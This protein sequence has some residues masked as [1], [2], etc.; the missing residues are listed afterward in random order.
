MILSLTGQAQDIDLSKLELMDGISISVYARVNNPRQ[1]T[2][3]DDGTVYVGTRSGAGGRVF[4]L[5]NKDNNA[6]AEEV[7][8]IDK[9]LT[10]PHGVTYKDG[11][12]YVGARS[13]I[14]RY[15]DIEANLNNSKREIITD[16]LPTLSRHSQKHIAFGPDGLL[17]IPVGAPCNICIPEEEIFASLLTLDVN[18]EDKSFT[19][20]ARGIRN[21]IGYDWDPRTGELWFTDNG[22]D[23]LGDNMPAEELN[24]APMRGMHFGYPFVH[25]GDTLDKKFGIGKKPSDYTPPAQKL[26]P[27]AAALGMTFYTG[28][29]FPEN[30]KNNIIIAEHGSWNR[31]DDAGHTG[32]RV[33][34]VSIENNKAVKYETLISGWLQNNSSWGQ[35]TDILQ[36]NDGS[37]LI[38]DD[39]A[40]A[41]Y[42]VTYNK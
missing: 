23:G 24:H 4:A 26:A 22:G 10:S 37:F 9:G 40:N 42:R 34:M 5:L 16:K 7:I 15:N 38:S 12:L 11:D 36:L 29:M 30:F 13:T 1:M 19:H 41:I 31:S 3:G 6:E 21:T 14:Y 33:T 27:H 18:S 17:Y 32:N 20:Y 39:E 8:E 35:P 25:Q 2:L 28:D